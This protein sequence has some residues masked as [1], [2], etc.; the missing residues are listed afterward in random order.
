VTAQPN[1]E[2]QV[3]LFRNQ[4]DRFPIRDSQ[5]MLDVQ[6]T[7]RHLKVLRW[8]SCLDTQMGCILAFQLHPRNHPVDQNPAIVG[9]ELAAKGRVKLFNR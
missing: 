1:E 9:I 3:R 8:R 4:H 2:L 5:S 6:R 7:K